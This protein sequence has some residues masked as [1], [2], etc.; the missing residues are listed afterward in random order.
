MV[1]YVSLN[2]NNSVV[3]FNLMT[4]TVGAEIPLGSDPLK[5]SLTASN[6]QVQPGNSANFAA[7]LTAGYYGQDGIDWIQNGAVVSQFLNEPPT[8]VAVG[9]SRFVDASNLFGWSSTYGATGLLHFVITGKGLLETSGIAGVYGMGAFDTDG[10]NLYD[11]NGQVFNASTGAL[12]GTFSQISNYSPESAVLTDTSSGR[13]FFLDQY[14]GVLAFDSASLAEV[15]TITSLPVTSPANR[16]QHWGL[17]GLSMLP[18]NYGTSG[19]DLLLLRTGLFYPAVGP[20]PSPAAYSLNPSSKAAQGPNFTLTVNGS[21]F[22][23][24]AAVLWNGVYRTTK[25]ITSTKLVADI[26]ASDIATSGQA[27]ITVFNPAPGGGKSVT[28]N[29]DIN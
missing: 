4:Q 29:F 10:I 19:Y 13:T 24:G 1:L 18:Y 14:N 27:K 2:G 15:G 22:V 8:N 16:L 7:T 17:D 21:Q 6:L 26:P 20:N 25:W 11:V 23:Q 12:V 28:L 5:G 3:P 9:G